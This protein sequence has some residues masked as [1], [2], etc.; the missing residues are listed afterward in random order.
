MSYNGFPGTEMMWD[1]PGSQM[2]KVVNKSER[3]DNS[4]MMVNSSST[5]HFNCSTGE[6]RY[7]SCYVGDVTSDLFSVCEYQTLKLSIQM[8]NVPKFYPG[9]ILGSVKVSGNSNALYLTTL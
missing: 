9:Y 6:L 1:V 3:T 2:W 8:V 5:A 4:T 7:L